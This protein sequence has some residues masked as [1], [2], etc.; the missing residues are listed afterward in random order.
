[1]CGIN[2]F[3][4]NK[5]YEKH[6]NVEKIIRLMNS[7]IIHRGP[8]EEG[9]FANDLF[10]LGMR[11]LSII[12]LSTG[13]QP[14]YNEDKNLI[15]IFNGEIYNHSILRKRLIE[16]G[17][18]FTTNSDTEVIVHA[19]EEYGN[20]CLDYLDGMFAF[21]IYN[22]QTETLFLA[23]DR[24]GEKPLYYYH[25]KDYFIFGS[26]IKGLLATKKIEKKINKKALNQYLQLSFI[27]SPE[28]IFNKINKL[29]A[30]H[31]LIM[32]DHEIKIQCYWDAEYNNDKLITDYKKCK[33]LLRE[34]MFKVVERQMI[35]HVPLGSFLSGGI[36]STIITGIMSKLSKKPIDTF[37]I[38]FREK[39][40]DESNR[41]KIASVFHRTVHHIYYLDYNLV[42]DEL[43]DIL[44]NLDEP[45]A[46]P[47]AIPT[48]M[49]SKYARQF[50]KVVL[51]G[52]GGDEVFAGYNKYLVNYYTNLYK[53]IPTSIR[54]CLIN[55]II[56]KIPDRYY[57]TRKI[58]KVID[59]IDRDLF[60]QRKEM[61]CLGFKDSELSNLLK[62]EYLDS[63]HLSFIKEY[64]DRYNGKA[65]EISQALYT[66]QK[67]VLEGC[68]LT[69]VD[70]SSMLASIETRAPFIS[71]DIIELAAQIP[72]EFKIKSKKLKIILKDTFKD[73][74]PDELLN[75][76]KHGFAAPIGVWFK[77]Q[78]K[79]K[80]IEVFSEDKIEEQGIFNY[81]YIKTLFEE[82]IS[83][84]KDR[85]R[86]LWVIFVFQWWYDHYFN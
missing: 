48:F 82:H 27:P 39:Q 32:V 54:N 37:T 80:L 11:R 40:Y 21:A 77:S 53:K 36:D 63:N 2:G 33:K 35:S 12:D 78:L 61:M 76:P 3:F 9:I 38:G 52:D 10:G 24:T 46:D 19:F 6:I 15:I 72:N 17:H 29:P 8:D 51:T 49:V 43:V 81:E 64:Y 69:K 14:I 18:F 55:K 75:K 34:T 68:M 47:S 25:D 86:E 5:L 50:V 7:Q 83:E 13:S 74:I 23:R 41:A 70:R 22:F 4:Q 57:Q 20:K 28:T 65:D 85:S 45:F 59:N 56:Y 16:K 66:D 44:N 31:F 58:R 60:T 62:A 84:K 42:L 71:R 30:G 1:M 73:L 79:D 26:E 67:V